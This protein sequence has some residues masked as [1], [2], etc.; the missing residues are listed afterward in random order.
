MNRDRL[1]RNPPVLKSQPTFIVIALLVMTVTSV[2]DAQT[3]TWDGEG[4]DGFWRTPANWDPDGVPDGPGSGAVI[5]APGPTIQGFSYTIGQLVVTV[6]GHLVVGPSARLSFATPIIG[7][8]NRGQITVLNR[9]NLGGPII[10]TGDIFVG[11]DNAA[12]AAVLDIQEFGATVS[13]GGAFPGFTGEIE[14][15]FRSEI[16]GGTGERLFFDDQRVHGFGTIQADFTNQG[17]SVIAADVENQVLVLL[18]PAGSGGSVNEATLRANAEGTLRLLDLT[19][20]NT[21][22]ILAESDS[23]VLLDGTTVTGGTLE[24]SGTGVIRVPAASAASLTD[25]TILHDDSVMDHTDLFV[26]NRSDLTLAG[27]IDNRGEIEVFNNSVFPNNVILSAGDVTLTGGGRLRL[28]GENVAMTGPPGTFLTLEDQHLQGEGSI[29][30]CR[31]NFVI[32]SPSIIEADVDGSTLTLSPDDLILNGGTLLADAGAS[33]RLRG[34]VTNNETIQANDG[35]IF[36]F[37]T[38][39]NNMNGFLDG[40]KYFVIDSGRGASISLSRT[41]VET[42]GAEA[43]IFLVGPNSEIFFGTLS[44][45]STLQQIDGFLEL[46]QRNFVRTANGELRI[47]GRLAVR[48]GSVF[49]VGDVLVLGPDGQIDGD[50]TVRSESAFAGGTVAPGESPGVLTLDSNVTLEATAQLHIE[51]AG[52]TLGT[53]FDHLTVT[54]NLTLG[55]ELQVSLTDDFVPNSL[56]TFEIVSASSISGSFSNTTDNR[57]TTSDGRWTMSVIDFQENNYALLRPAS[58][59]NF[60][61]TPIT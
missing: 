47:D 39:T 18:P 59:R 25:V 11:S 45:E 48:G 61:I 27:T 46:F 31:I 44:L 12:I 58:A 17:Q 50:G 14:M 53:E 13:T 57:V 19:L 8:T 41:G 16:R 29:G 10:N 60:F 3:L 22:K 49:D 34:I 35:A 23:E 37:A 6:S 26:A 56:D 54:K 33:L 52:T 36:G 4:G 9:L 40:G 51:F 32:D 20:T 30:A 7:F 1:V 42:L 15:G 5:E 28:S 21:G 38:L 2:V 24:T 55:G 43:W